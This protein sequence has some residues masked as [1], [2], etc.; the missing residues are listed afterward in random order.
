MGMAPV[1]GVAVP[2]SIAKQGARPSSDVPDSLK[3]AAKAK[4]ER[5]RAGGRGGEVAGIVEQLAGWHAYRR[6]STSRS[7]RIPIRMGSKSRQRSTSGFN[8]SVRS[9]LNDGAFA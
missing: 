1:D 4:N 6:R 8:D 5:D 9:Q 3:Q 2:D 7:I